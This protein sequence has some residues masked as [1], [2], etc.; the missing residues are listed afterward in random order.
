MQLTKTA[1]KLTQQY[2]AQTLSKGN[3]Y[4]LIGSSKPQVATYCPPTNALKQYRAERKLPPPQP[5]LHCNGG[6]LLGTLNTVSI[7]ARVPDYEKIAKGDDNAF[8]S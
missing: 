7:L 5:Q 4:I 8:E 3:Y 6:L 1:R 2:M